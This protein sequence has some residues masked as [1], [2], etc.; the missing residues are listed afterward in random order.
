LL[1]Y[2]RS[3]LQS[4]LSKENTIADYQIFEFPNGIRFIHKQVPAT[5][6]AHC[7][8]I[9]DVGSRDEQPNEQ[10]IAH[11]WEHMAF[12]GTEKRKSFHIINRLEILGGEIN[13]YTTKE[14]IAFHASVLATHF[15]KAVDLLT[16]ITFFSIFPDKE[17]EKEKGVILEEMSMYKDTP[18]DAIQDDLDLLL[19]PNHPLGNNILGTDESINSFKRAD[20]QDFYKR[21]VG[22]E[23]LIFSSVGPMDFELAVKKARPFLEKISPLETNK[24]RMA[25]QNAIAQSISEFKPISQAHLMLGCRAFPLNHEKRLALFLLNNVL[26]GPAL[27]SR[28][29]FTIREKH[30]LVYTVESNYAP[31]LDTGAFTIYLGTELKNLEKAENLVKKEILNLQSNMLS[32]QQLRN[33]KEQIKGQ[34]AMAEEGNMMMMLMLGKSILDMGRVESLA[35]IFGEIDAISSKDLIEVANQVWAHDQWVRLAFL[36]QKGK[37]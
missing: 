35:E 17:I 1:L 36:P 31:Y 12:K 27:T 19:F 18:D 15:E 30:G 9:L 11:F 32:I 4:K 33:A 28:L 24:K 3:L 16:D 14:K 5:K 37:K 2:L 21:N 10:G 34:L 22:V 6:I 29:N 23:R 7:G 13:A 26:G 8:F 20:F 25:P